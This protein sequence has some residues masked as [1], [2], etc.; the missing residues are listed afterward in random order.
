MK[1]LSYNSIL[2]RKITINSQ[3]VENSWNQGREES[4]NDLKKAIEDEKDA[5]WR[6]N[7]Q[8]LLIAAKKENV[9]LQLEAA[10]RERMMM[11]YSEVSS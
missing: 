11:V 1:L 4:I 3:A 9:L 2:Y 5:Q 6:A 7:G 8:E 10:Y